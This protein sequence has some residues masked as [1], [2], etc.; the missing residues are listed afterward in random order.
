MTGVQTCA[1]PICTRDLL[2]TH[3]DQLE[4]IAEALL[5]KETLSVA[6][7][8]DLLG[9]KKEETA[10][11]ADNASGAEASD[12]P[13]TVQEESASS[14]KDTTAADNGSTGNYSDV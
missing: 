9:M 12:A 2:R 10:E 13:E 4:K 1:L 5:E 7:L 14:S 11:E 8:Y 6:E 3:R